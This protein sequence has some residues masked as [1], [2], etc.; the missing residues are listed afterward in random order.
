[1]AATF[2]AGAAT[3]VEAN[4]AAET[5]IRVGIFMVRLQL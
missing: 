1:V 2:G 4:A 3:A 5:A